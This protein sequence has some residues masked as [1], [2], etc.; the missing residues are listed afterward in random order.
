MSANLDTES[1]L[2]PHSDNVEEELRR[3]RLAL[4]AVYSPTSST[5]PS[6]EWFEQRQL[7]DRY[8]TSFQTKTVSWMVCDQLLQDSNA[9]PENQQHQFFAAQTLHTKCRGD[10]HELPASAL[11]S[12]RDS[13]LNHLRRANF[14][15]LT[16]RLALCVSAL[17][18]QMQ[19]N[20]VINDLLGQTDIILPILRV[21][22]E[23]TA[24]DR[25]FLEHEEARF[26]MR[27]HLIESAPMVF[28]FLQSLTQTSTMFEVFHAW[29]RYVPVHPNALVESPLLQASVRAL[30]SKEL[31]EQA[32]DVVVEV[33][34]MY[35]SH[36]YGNEGLV[37]LLIPLLTQLPLEHALQQDDEDVQR[38]YCR[39]V[40]E[41]GES[42]LSLILSKE[43][44]NASSQLV[45]WVLRCSSIPDSEIA[46]I[47]LHFWYRLVMDLEVIDP[48]DWRQELV[49]IYTPHLLELIQVCVKSLMRY[50]SEEI[51]EDRLDDIKRHRFYVAETIEDC[52]RLLGGQAVIHKLHELLHQMVQAGEW[53]G[54]ESC[55]ACI[56]AI[57]RFVPSDESELLPVCFQLIPQ[58][59]NDIPPLRFTA[60][61]MVGKFAS[62]L[63]VHSQFLQPL[64]PYLAQGLS[65]RETAPAA[66][67]AIK[68]LC[69]C[70]NQ[71]FAI[72]DP[73]LQLYLEITAAGRL[74]LADE[75]EILEG[76][77][78][79][80]YDL[81]L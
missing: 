44:P 63:A 65:V 16:T 24:S 1:Q 45:Q 78:R 27:D 70:S 2:P 5:S 74:D 80:E 46:T 4:T 36:Q 34:R 60:S 59:R 75:L 76:V 43:H 23:E 25:L 66:A 69:E 29:I 19:W 57:H 50:P 62:W 15:A 79:G 81:L 64:L 3:I 54:I 17:A 20:T 48:Y 8:L 9:T 39:V 30:Y 18:V 32:T 7:A 56:G 55:L 35:P 49:D 52:C 38:A 67:V 61:K 72:A 40:T 42:Y 33:L 47:T 37:Q 73:V 53:Q 31:L 13:L 41:M 22:P 6:P 71:N 14:A 68:E 77:C 51:S 58:L 21:L 26:R 28:R 12:L 11:P 10:I